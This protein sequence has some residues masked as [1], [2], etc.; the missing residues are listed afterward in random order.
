M[1]QQLKKLV[2]NILEWD[3]DAD[4]TEDN[5]GYNMREFMK[6]N[7]GNLPSAFIVRPDQAH[8]LMRDFQVD[9]PL[10][11]YGFNI[12][13]TKNNGSYKL[14]I[15]PTR[16]KQMQQLRKGDSEMVGHARRELE[17]AGLFTENKDQDYDGFIGK[18]VLAL[19]KAFDSWTANDPSKMQAVKSV[20]DYVIT[21]DLLS[22]PSNDPDEWEEYEVEGQAFTRNR[23]NPMFITRDGMKTWFNLRTK[24]QG[25]CNDHKTGKPL[26]G[27]ED[28]N[29]KAEQTAKDQEGSADAG[30]AGDGEHTVGPAEEPT[31]TESR[32]E[33]E[34]GDAEPSTGADSSPVEE[35]KLDAGVEQK[36]SAN[37][38][39]KKAPAK[40]SKKREA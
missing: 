40:K 19:V 14:I 23:R 37:P 33:G 5:I 7:M 29:G 8:I 32:S 26:E 9:P 22:P 27:V 17:I 21:G 10:D 2:W 4:L 18:G 36:S 24:Q 15:V 30:N 38:G 20:F 1:A 28:P 12:I 3:R 35:G 31:E 39:E 25:I 6:A 11:P 34:A 13:H 16:S